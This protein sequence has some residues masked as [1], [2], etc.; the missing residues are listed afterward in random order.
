[1]SISFNIKTDDIT[2]LEYLKCYDSILI[3]EIQI[4]QILF[5][6]LKDH[7]LQNSGYIKD[8]LINRGIGIFPSEKSYRAM[9]LLELGD[10]K[11]FDNDKEMQFYQSLKSLKGVLSYVSPD[12]REC[13]N[14]LFEGMHRL[15]R[16]IDQI[17]EVKGNGNS[18]L[19]ILNYKKD[20]SSV[21]E[22]TR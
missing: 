17:F 7:K 1:M 14:S 22:K 12:D 15:G 3:Q 13:L 8:G 10:I 20:F 5:S 21:N 16:G 9:S 6:R 2:V 19:P 18:Y 11:F 4:L